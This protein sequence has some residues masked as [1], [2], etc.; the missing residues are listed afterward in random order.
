MCDCLKAVEEE[1]DFAI[2]CRDAMVT[3]TAKSQIDFAIVGYQASIDAI[4]NSQK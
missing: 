3:E 2:N 1:R 4:K